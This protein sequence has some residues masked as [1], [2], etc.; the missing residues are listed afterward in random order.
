MATETTYTQ[1]RADFA[2]LL[3]GWA[4]TTKSWSCAAADAARW[5]WWPP[6]SCPL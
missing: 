5:P 4:T 1:A 6:M 3:A 2:R